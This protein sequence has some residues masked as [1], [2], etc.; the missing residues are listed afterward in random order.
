MLTGPWWSVRKAVKLR[1]TS[2]LE[3]VAIPTAFF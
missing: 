2:P 3:I 1:V